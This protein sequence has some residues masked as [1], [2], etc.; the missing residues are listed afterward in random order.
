MG[1]VGGRDYGA[2]REVKGVVILNR[3]KDPKA[4]VNNKRSSIAFR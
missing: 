4:T 3:V 1:T 2:G